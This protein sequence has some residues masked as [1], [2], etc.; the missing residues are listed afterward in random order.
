[1]C[2]Y[3]SRPYSNIYSYQEG[4]DSYAFISVDALLVLMNLDGDISRA[5][6]YH[7][8][9]WKNLI[10]AVQMEAPKLRI[11]VKMTRFRTALLEKMLER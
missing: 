9:I 4:G 3:L 11:H 5:A 10:S 8:L 6:D 2:F 7:K 1:M